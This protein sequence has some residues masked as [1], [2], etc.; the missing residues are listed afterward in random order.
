LS[1]G[2]F[3]ARSRVLALIAVVSACPAFA[4]DGEWKFALDQQDQPS[5]TYSESGEEVL[6]IG[7]G[8]AFGLRADYPGAQDRK[9][10]AA[11]AIANAKTRLVLKGEIVASEVGKT[12]PA[13]FVQWDLGYR[14]QDPAL[15]GN[16]WHA[17]KD[18]LFNLFDSGRPLTI[19]A[20]GKKYV[21]PPVNAA[22]WKARFKRIC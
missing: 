2:G 5:L 15:Y 11:I 16:G 10:E 20:E 17:L 12:G 6:S 8:R 7:C 14:R 21:L 4:A 18:R 22:N 19:S 9:G 3:L 13:Q 1:C